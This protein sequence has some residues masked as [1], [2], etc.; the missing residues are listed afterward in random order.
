[1]LRQ[2]QCAEMEETNMKTPEDDDY[3]EAMALIEH[4]C[5]DFQSPMDELTL[6]TLGFMAQDDPYCF[7]DMKWSHRRFDFGWSSFGARG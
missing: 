3:D 6:G 2:G 5:S 7:P 4:G 1:M